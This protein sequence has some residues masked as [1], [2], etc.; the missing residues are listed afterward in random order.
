MPVVHRTDQPTGT[1]GDTSVPW[2]ATLVQPERMVG[3]SEQV[4]VIDVAGPEALTMPAQVE[5]GSHR[6]EVAWQSEPGQHRRGVATIRP[7]VGRYR[8]L[9]RLGDVLLE[10]GKLV[11]AS[12]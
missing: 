6:S 12:P 1:Y 8:V 2:G 10:A 7:G 4:I 5:V 11:V 9:V 3:G